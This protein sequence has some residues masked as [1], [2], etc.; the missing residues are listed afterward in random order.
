M[1]FW[2]L[3]VCLFEFSRHSKPDSPPQLGSQ[4]RTVHGCTKS[5]QTQ[6]QL[7]FLLWGFPKQSSCQHC[8]TL[9]FSCIFFSLPRFL[10][11]IQLKPKQPVEGSAFIAKKEKAVYLQH[12]FARALRRVTQGDAQT[13][14]FHSS[15]WHWAVQSDVFTFCYGTLGLD[16]GNPSVLHQPCS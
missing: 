8:L 3:F 14:H 10:T 2:F 12:S 7:R 9:P 16:V 11:V 13:S 5:I 6:S 15:S 1:G 4:N